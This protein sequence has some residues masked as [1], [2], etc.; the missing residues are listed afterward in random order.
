[1][2]EQPRTDTGRPESDRRREAKIDWEQ[3]DRRLKR[4]IVTNW[5]IKLIALLT[6]IILWA[7]LITQDPSL[8]RDKVF[9]DVSVTVSG[10][11][12]LKRNGLV[13]TSGI[14]D[15][16]GVTLRVEVPQTQYTAA[17]AS[18]FNA[19]IDLSRLREAGEQ[20]VRILTSN[21]ATYGTVVDVEPSTVTL[22]LEDYA[23]RYRIP[24]NVVATGDMPEGWWAT[25]STA[26]PYY[27]AVSGPRSLVSQIAQAQVTLDQSLLPPRAGNYSQS[28]SFRL[29]NTAGEEVVSDLLEVTSESV[30]L[31]AINVE[32]TIYPQR[33]I[34]VSELGLVTGTP[35]EGYEVKRVTVTPS[36]ITAAG[37]AEALDR[38][39]TLYADA[40]VDISGLSESVTR[41]V[42]VRRPGELR[43]LSQTSLTVA[44]EI[45][46]VIGER[47]FEGVRVTL[48]GVG[49]GLSASQQTRYADVTVSGPVNWLKG[50][51]YSVLHLSCDA[52]GLAKG[53]HD[54][55]IRCAIDGADSIEWHYETQPES[56]QVTLI[57]KE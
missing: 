15:M 17:Q 53:E 34:A 32:Q 54:L 33:E 48:T 14:Q 47:L 18:T 46:P 5:P 30:L 43:S 52:D 44:V 40:S 31:D 8:T 19:R 24:V 7:A 6:A 41:Q 56:I 35:A 39:E 37:T 50:L 23:T 13:V 38:L 4:L 57:E 12:I 20:E 49:A 1:M 28:L 51:S 2:S 27:V 9:T 22:V 10:S 21:S 16:T 55:L 36:V 25:A 3:M 11:D 29:M 42:S 26:D 45:G